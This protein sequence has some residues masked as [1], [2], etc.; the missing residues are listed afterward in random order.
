M[1]N[2]SVRVAGA[3]V[4]VH[5]VGEAG[6]PIVFVHGNTGSHR[7]FLRQLESPLAE[8]FWLIAVDLPGPGPAA[9][10]RSW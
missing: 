6:L 7:G 8:R 1:R 4:A 5:C 9:Y 2:T 10:R 3:A